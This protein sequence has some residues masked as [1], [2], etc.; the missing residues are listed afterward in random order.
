MRVK[1]QWAFRGG[2]FRYPIPPA[3]RTAVLAPGFRSSGDVRVFAGGWSSQVEEFA[4]AA[5][6]ARLPQLPRH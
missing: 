3:P 1:V 4:P 6:A 2:Q 5:I